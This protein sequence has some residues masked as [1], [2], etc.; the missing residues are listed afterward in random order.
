MKE[1]VKI[2][3]CGF[4]WHCH[5]WFISRELERHGWKVVHIIDDKRNWVPRAG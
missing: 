4:P 3:G 2:G 1:K 5:R